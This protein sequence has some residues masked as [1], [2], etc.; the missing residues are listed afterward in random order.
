MLLDWKSQYC[1]SDYTIRAI[2]RFNAIP[3][4]LPMIFFTELEQNI[5]K[6][7]WKHKRP[8]TVKAMFKRKAELEKSGSLS[9]DYTT[10]KQ[11]GTDTKTE[12]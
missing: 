2:Y 4:K 3:I 5:F 10:S 9:I 12:V 7:V 1:P 8:E 6:F 11:Y